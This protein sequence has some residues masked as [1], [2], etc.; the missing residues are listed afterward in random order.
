[1]FTTWDD[2]SDPTKA[3]WGSSRMDRHAGRSCFR[4]LSFGLER[5]AGRYL[6]KMIL[7][8]TYF[9]T[10][11]KIATRAFRWVKDSININD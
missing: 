8:I 9:N 5:H 3:F 7:L 11:T 2:Q 1:M 10:A 4:F 6:L